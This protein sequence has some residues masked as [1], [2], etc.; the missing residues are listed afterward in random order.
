MRKF[1]RAFKGMV[2]PRAA[3]ASFALVDILFMALAAVMSGAETAS[4]MEQWSR[5]KQAL[6]GTMLKLDHGTPSHDTFSRVF[7]LLDPVAFEAAFRRFMAGF[8]KANGLAGGGTIAIDGKALRG[9]YER[10]CA[11]TPLHLVNAFAVEARLVLSMRRAAGRNEAA[12]A[13]EVLEMLALRNSVVTADA[14]HCHK[15]FAQTVLAR[16]GQYVLALK[17]NQSKLFKMVESRFC[18]AGKRRSSERL[19]PL[20]HGRHERRRAT[21]IRD[22]SLCRQFPGVAALGRVTCYRQVRGRPADKPLVRYY[23]MSCVLSARAL[24]DT[25]RAHWGIENRLHWVLDADFGEDADRTRKDNA[26]DNFAILRRLALNIARCHPA[27][28]SMRLKLKRAGWDDTFLISL[29]SHM[30]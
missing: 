27:A 7:R 9:A 13:L 21:V 11:A 8:A 30:R 16:E 2:D 23:L 22:N 28:M 5:G 6:L 26:P 24:L 20:T 15:R 10:G 3:N 19:E 4:E 18:H 17:R 1:R 29:L 25:V 12:T 14:L